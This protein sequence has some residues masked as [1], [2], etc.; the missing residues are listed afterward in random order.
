MIFLPK[1]TQG[2]IGA[3]Q[4]VVNLPPIRYTSRRRHRRL[5]RARPEETLLDLRFRKT[6]GQ[7][8]TQLS[9]FGSLQVV[10]VMLFWT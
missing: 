9:Q 1:Q 5:G 4:L 8:P 6:L 3:P 2:H 10:A 7:W